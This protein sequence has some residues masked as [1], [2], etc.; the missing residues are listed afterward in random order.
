M[1]FWNGTIE[2]IELL[3]LLKRKYY[4]VNTMYKYTI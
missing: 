2:T 3:E 1:D 4:A